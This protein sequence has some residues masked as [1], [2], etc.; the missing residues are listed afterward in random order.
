MVTKLSIKTLSIILFAFLAAGCG[1]NYPL[2]EVFPPGTMLI[3]ENFS[4]TDK[5]ASKNDYGSG[6]QVDGMFVLSMNKQKG[7][8]INRSGQKLQNAEVEISSYPRST[9]GKVITGLVC[10]MVDE[11]NFVFFAVNSTG[12]SKIGKIKNGEQIIYAK[13]PDVVNSAVNTGEKINTITAICS[14]EKLELLV[15]GSTLLTANDPLIN[16]GDVGFFGEYAYASQAEILFDNYRVR[17][18]LVIK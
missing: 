18:P 16:A 6:K 1:A 10:R 2:G 11:N 13:S 14:A 12:G 15:N 3:H 8:M 7:M 17:V 4:G 9:N 5:Y